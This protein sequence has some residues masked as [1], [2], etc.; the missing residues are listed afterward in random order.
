MVTILAHGSRITSLVN[1]PQLASGSD[2]GAIKI[3][4][5]ETIVPTTAVNTPTAAAPVVPVSAT[6]A[7]CHASQPGPQCVRSV[8][9]AA[10]AG[11]R[12][13]VVW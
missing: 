4:P 10:A 7:F 5:V 9:G 12:V 13:V 6:T 2:D 1:I 8:V 3:V 11:Y